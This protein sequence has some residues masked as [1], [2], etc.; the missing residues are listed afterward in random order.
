M[1][2]FSNFSFIALIVATLFNMILGAL[3]YHPR[4]LGGPWV[5]AQGFREDALKPTPLSYLGTFLVALLMSWVI[6]IFVQS[7]DV[8][9]IAQALQL[10]FFIWLGFIV[11]THFSGIIWA[12]KPFEAYLIDISFYLLSIIGAAIIFVLIP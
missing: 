6:G 12:K 2:D 10:G 3:W 4:F 5:D 8:I 1:L 9:T 11:S 7:L